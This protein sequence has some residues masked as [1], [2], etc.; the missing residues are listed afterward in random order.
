MNYLDR[1]DLFAGLDEAQMQSLVDRSRLRSF[2]AS[3]VVVN[4]GDEG[5][6][7]YV[8][9]SGSLKAYLTDKTGREVT[10]SLLDEGDY[11]GELALL[12]DAP[13]SAS[14][15]AVTRSELLQVPR[16][17]F[18]ALIEEHPASMQVVIRNLVARIRALS[19][20]V[21][22]LALEDVFRRVTRAFETLAVERDG[23]RLIER[24]LTQQDVASLVGASREMINRVL[25]EL[26][27]GGYV[28]IEQ[29]HIVLRRKLPT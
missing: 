10:L 11:F 16:S 13:R 15:A 21:R 2:V 27:A 20:N 4:E 17:A 28:E 25:R 5:G 7:M 26:V 23:Q 29:H 6:S 19:D 8:V 14:V 18:L 9:Q 24:R 22:S 12:D 3:T 1:V